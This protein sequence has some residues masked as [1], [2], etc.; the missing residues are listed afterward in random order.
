[1]KNQ[2]IV[3]AWGRF[4]AEMHEISRKFEQEHSEIAKRIQT[5]REIHNGILSDVKLDETDEIDVNNFQHFGVLHGDLNCSN[6]NFDKING[7]MNVFDT[8]QVQRGFF[9]WDVSRAIFTTYMLENAGMPNSGE[10]VADANCKKFTE[11]IVEG[12]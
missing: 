3:F 12:Y 2:K 8:D 1:M 7:V 9:L 5:W 4:F 10:P 6:F 11:W